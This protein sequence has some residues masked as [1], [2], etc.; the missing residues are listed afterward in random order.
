MNNYIPIELKG[1]GD[2]GLDGFKGK[3]IISLNFPKTQ[4][5]KSGIWYLEIC[6]EGGESWKINSN[7]TDTEKY[8]DVASIVIEQ[9]MQSLAD[10]SCEIRT[11]EPVDFVLRECRIAT[12]YTDE[13]D[14]SDCAI[15]LISENSKELLIATAPAPGAVTFLFYQWLY[16]D[17]YPCIGCYL[18]GLRWRKSNEEI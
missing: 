5:P 6:W 18:S 8:F 16:G 17:D 2:E 11:L 12:D 10:V 1:F 14:V 3:K 15:A 9:T 13:A 7:F 4:S